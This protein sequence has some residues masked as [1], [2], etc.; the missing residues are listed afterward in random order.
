MQNPARVPTID[1]AGQLNEL[2][3]CCC[4][5]AAEAVAGLEPWLLATGCSTE[6]PCH[7]EGTVFCSTVSALVTMIQ[8]FPGQVTTE[9]HVNYMAF[10]EQ[11]PT[12]RARVTRSD[13]NC[14]SCIHIAEKHSIL[15]LPAMYVSFAS[16]NL[17]EF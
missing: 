15:S 16:N 9:E 8:S 12:A 2:A 5:I 11:G 17:S 14:N 1:V 10:T 6:R 4:A 13:I 3:L 7:L